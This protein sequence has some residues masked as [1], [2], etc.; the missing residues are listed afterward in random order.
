MRL[1]LAL[2]ISLGM[3][4]QH[5]DHAQHHADVD[6]KGDRVMGFPHDQTTHHFRLHKDGGAIEVTAN[7]AEDAAN[8]DKIRMHLRHIAVK[9]QEG[10]FA[11]PM[12]IHSRVVPGS[13]VMKERKAKIR[14]QFEELAQG[15]RVRIETRDEGALRAIHEFLRFQISDHRTGDS[16][17][18]E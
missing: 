14:Y 16:G 17:K 3:W 10:D 12:L 9:F 4:A 11:M 13:D 1:L 18:V 15:G 7:R 8:R 5:H 6:K 2:A